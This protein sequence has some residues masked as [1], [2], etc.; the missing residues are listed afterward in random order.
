MFCKNCKGEFP[1][2][3]FPKDKTRKNGIYPYCKSCNRK[4]VRRYDKR[5]KDLVFSHYSDGKFICACC[6]EEK[7]EFLVLDHTNGGGNKHRLEIQGNGGPNAMYR[8]I[9]KN[10]YPSGFRVLCSNCNHS[11]GA[12]GYCPHKGQ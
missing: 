7:R 9:V 4:R 3:D 6:S 8:W 10:N 5:T 2:E 12:Y 11:Y 1:E